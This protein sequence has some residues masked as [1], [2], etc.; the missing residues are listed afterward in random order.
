MKESKSVLAR[1]VPGTATRDD[2]TGTVQQ[3]KP[4]EDRPVA[5]R[6]VSPGP[7]NDM[8]PVR[9]S[10]GECPCASNQS[11]NPSVALI[12]HIPVVSWRR[13]ATAIQR[14]LRRRN[15]AGV[16]NSGSMLSCRNYGGPVQ[17][18]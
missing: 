5:H 1:H 2:R 3:R 6:L 17:D 13:I 10:Y 8:R 11:V 9:M 12:T 15:A 18:A 4:L 14:P 16:R 7:G